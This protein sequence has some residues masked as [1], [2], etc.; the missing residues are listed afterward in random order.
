MRFFFCFDREY[1]VEDAERALHD[2][3][4]VLTEVK[5]LLDIGDRSYA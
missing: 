4:F 1:G 3:V 2:A 5:R